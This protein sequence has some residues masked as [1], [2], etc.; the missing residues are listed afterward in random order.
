MGSSHHHHHHSQD[1]NSISTTMS[2]YSIQQSQKMLT[3][4]QIDYATNTSSNTV[5][6]YLHNVGETTISYLQNS[7]VY[8]GPN[9]QL[10][11]VGYNSGSSPYWTVTSNSLQPGSKVKII[12]YLSSPLSSNQY[13]TIQIVTPN[14]YTVSYMF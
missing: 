9:G 1:P 12:I 13:Y 6:A 3:Q 14:G 2:S 4:L 5:V 10:Q 8:F 7:V 11:P